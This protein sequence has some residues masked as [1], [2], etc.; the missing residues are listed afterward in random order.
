MEKYL[1]KY[2]IL[3]ILA[4]VLTSITIFSISRLQIILLKNNV[5][6]EV[7]KHITR[8]ICNNILYF[9]NL[10]ITIVIYLDMKKFNFKSWPILLLTVCMN[11]AGVLIFLIGYRNEI[12]NKNN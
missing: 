12:N 4:I 7:A 8:I 10:L 1:R 5:D 9:F 6:Y 3:V 11:W 2:F